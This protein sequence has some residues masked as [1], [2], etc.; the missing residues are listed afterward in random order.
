MKF[1]KQIFLV[2]HNPSIVVYGDAE[3]IILCSNETKKIKY[4]QLV[5]ENKKHQ[6]EI[7]TVLDGGYYIF[8]QRARK[9][10][11]KKIKL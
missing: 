11:I 7:C 5:L 4:Q 3:S 1:Q 2:T 8:E 9:Y 6:K 10:D